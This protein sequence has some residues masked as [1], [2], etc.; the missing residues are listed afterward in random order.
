MVTARSACPRRHDVPTRSVPAWRASAGSRLIS[1]RSCSG[2]GRLGEHGSEQRVPEHRGAVRPGTLRVQRRPGA[3]HRHR[4][5][6]H[7]PVRRHPVPPGQ[8]RQRKQRE[9][10]KPALKFACNTEAP[11]PCSAS[12]KSPRRA[13]SS[14]PP[15]MVPWPMP[16][17]WK[18]PARIS[19]GHQWP[20]IAVA[21]G[22]PKRI[23]SLAAL[24]A[25]EI[26]LALAN[27][28]AASIAA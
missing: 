24:K 19:A 3:E 21:K 5:G 27:P 6:D 4:R 23:D 20:V 9:K 28:E 15:T 14:S 22:N 8:Q 16:R 10:R 26:R 11:A 1:S 12:S 13:I 7:H 25:P 18:S 2:D 17:N